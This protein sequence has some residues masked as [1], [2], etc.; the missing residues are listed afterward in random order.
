MNCKPGDRAVIVRGHPVCPC[1]ERLVGLTIKC[2]AVVDH[3]PILGPLWSSAWGPVPCACKQYVI[4]F[5]DAC[6]QP[7]RG[8]PV[9]ADVRE[10]DVVL[11]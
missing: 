2:E 5:P 9:P 3:D 6:L 10:L 4:T 8:E 11:P 7:I 1:L